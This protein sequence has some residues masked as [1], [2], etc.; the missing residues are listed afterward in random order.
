VFYHA[1]YKVS[2]NDKATRMFYLERAVH[3]IMSK[4]LLSRDLAS[5]RTPTPDGDGSELETKMFARF[6]RS[7][8]D[9]TPSTPGPGPR[10]RIRCKACR[11]VADSID[12]KT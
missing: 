10:R 4:W 1:S 8:S 3:E 9:S 11:W 5:L 6:P 12:V 2:R 7:P